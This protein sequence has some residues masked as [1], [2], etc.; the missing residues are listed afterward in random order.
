LLFLD[1]GVMIDWRDVF[2]ILVS[3]AVLPA[4]SGLCRGTLAQ[5]VNAAK[6][7]DFQI[8]RGAW[9]EVQFDNWVD[10]ILTGINDQDS[11]GGGRLVER[12]AVRLDWI[13]ATCKT[14][15]AQRKK[16]EIAGRGDIKRFLDEI[17]DIRR[18]YRQVKADPVETGK[19]EQRLGEIQTLSAEDFFGDSSFLSKTLQATL[20]DE[21]R[22]AYARGVAESARFSHRAAVL[23]AVQ[24]CDHAIGLK[25]EQRRRLT[26][27]FTVDTRQMKKEEPS[28]LPLQS[29]IVLNTA[30]LSGAR[31]K[32]IFDERQWLTMTKLLTQMQRGAKGIVIQE[33][34]IEA[35]PDPAPGGAAPQRIDK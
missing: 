26:E 25:D 14:S 20:S 4:I 16:L 19:L 27:L 9:N 31:L 2:K 6:L 35:E 34:V 7:L 1:E 10:Q 23:Q 18:R 11:L 5:E 8:E 3:I 21:Q 15:A 28:A 13:E 22:A 33:F 30:R 17:C 32:A 29:V 12:L 24:V